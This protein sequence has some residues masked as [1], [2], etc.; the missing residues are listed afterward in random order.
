MES[1]RRD[2]SND[3][4]E[5]WPILK[6]NQDTTHVLFSRPKQIWYSPKRVFCFKCVQTSNAACG[7]TVINDGFVLKDSVNQHCT[8]NNI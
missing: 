1:S 8:S 4:A 6:N 5:H 7:W 3:M 2:L